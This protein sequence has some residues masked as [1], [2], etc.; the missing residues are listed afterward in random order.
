[1]FAALL[2]AQLRDRRR[3]AAAALGA[4]IA[5][6]LIPFV[7]AGVPIIAATAAVV[8]GWRTA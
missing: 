1:L 5:A 8:V 4:V 7:P 2:A 3:V 6:A